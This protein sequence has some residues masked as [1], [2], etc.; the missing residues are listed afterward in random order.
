VSVG[1]GG[2]RAVFLVVDCGWAVYVLR[3]GDVHIVCC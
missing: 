3:M 2:V 1:V